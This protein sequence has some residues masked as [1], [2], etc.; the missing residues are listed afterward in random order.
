MLDC[1]TEGW[2][3]PS[4]PHTHDRFFFLHTF[5]FWKWVF[6]NAVTSI[7]NARHIVMT[8]P[9]CLMTS[10]RSVTSV[11]TM[12]YVT[13]YTTSVY[14]TREK[15]RFFIFP[16]GRIRVSEI[17]FAS[18]VVVCGNPSPVC[19]EKNF[20]HRVRARIFFYLVCKNYC[21]AHSGKKWDSFPGIVSKI[22]LLLKKNHLL[23]EGANSFLQALPLFWKR[24]ILPLKSSPY[25]KEAKYFMLVDG[26][27]L[28][29]I[30]KTCLYNFDPP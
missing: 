14:Q 9:W 17:R 16:T 26:F 8:I 20:Y 2:I 22:A 11:L 7:A 19:K 3:F 25:G 6:D 24:Y 12:P 18:T 28:Q 23:T 4:V 29:I 30:T 10:L 21:Y 15:S 27:V 13:S 5:L 1:K